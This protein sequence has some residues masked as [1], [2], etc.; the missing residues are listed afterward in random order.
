V[1]RGFAD[2]QGGAGEPDICTCTA[3]PGAILA[4]PPEKCLA[5]LFAALRKF[6]SIRKEL[7]SIC[8]QMEAAECC[9]TQLRMVSLGVMR[10]PGRT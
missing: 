4:Q 6:I 3:A 8:S 9:V 5:R 2:G 10:H 7:L 1:Q